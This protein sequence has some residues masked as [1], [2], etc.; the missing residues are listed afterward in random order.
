MPDK[1]V[2]RANLNPWSVNGQNW[3][4]DNSHILAS[5][6]SFISKGPKFP[7]MVKFGRLFHDRVHHHHALISRNNSLA[8]PPESF[9]E[10]AP[11]AKVERWES[12]NGLHG[13]RSWISNPATPILVDWRRTTQPHG[14]IFMLSTPPCF[15]FVKPAWP[16][17]FQRALTSLWLS[18]EAVFFLGCFGGWWLVVSICFISCSKNCLQLICSNTAAATTMFSRARF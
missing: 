9:E 6:V 12:K 10:A 4:H 16:H 18:H 14:R 1:F 2:W 8:I 3:P 13:N 7:N 5:H 15:A 11:E 17:V